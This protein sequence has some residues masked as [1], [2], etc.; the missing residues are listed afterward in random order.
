MTV[1]V[2]ATL[3]LIEMDMLLTRAEG[4]PL[5]GAVSAGFIFAV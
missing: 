1:L 2:T 4:L 5:N 3:F